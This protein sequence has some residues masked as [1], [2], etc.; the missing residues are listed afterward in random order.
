MFFFFSLCLFLFF[1]NHPHGSLTVHHKHVF[2]KCLLPLPPTKPTIEEGL[3]DSLGSPQPM[4]DEFEVFFFCF[5][6][7]LLKST[8]PSGPQLAEKGFK[9]KQH[10][11]GASRPAGLARIFC[12]E[13]RIPHVN[14]LFPKHITAVAECPPTHFPPWRLSV[15]FHLHM[16]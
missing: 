14:S 5:F 2:F 1:S 13:S 8:L 11:G 4:C 7:A 12:R 9:N 3:S 6:W 15:S 10:R 16:V